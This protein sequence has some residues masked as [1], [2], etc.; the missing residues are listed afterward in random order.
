MKDPTE[1]TNMVDISIRRIVIREGAD[2]QYIFLRE[3]AGQRGFPIVIGPSEAREIQRVVTGIQTER[4]LTHQLAYDA[5]R[6]LGAELKRVDIVALRKNTFFA[7]V[8]LQNEDGELR[9]VLDARPSDAV[10]LALRARCPLRVSEALLEQVRTDS[11]GP[12]PLTDPESEP[13]TR[14]EDQPDDTERE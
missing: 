4:P 7:Q 2:H 14:A 11:S 1:G 10:A 8:V 3:N 5:I 12:D 6:A 9:A 13:E